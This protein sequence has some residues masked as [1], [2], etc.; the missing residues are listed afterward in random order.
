MEAIRFETLGLS[1]NIMKSLERMHFTEPTEVQALTVTPFLEG[2]DL[3]VQSPT[4]TGKTAAFGM[5][6]LQMIDPEVRATQALILCPTRELAL[7]ITEVLRSLSRSGPDVR[8]VTVYGGEN[9]SRQLAALRNV[10]HI[11]VA[12]PGRLLDHMQRKTVRLNTLRMVVVDEVDR[13]LDMGFRNDLK[14]I[15]SATPTARQT[16]M[17]SATLPQEIVF[18]ANQYQKNAEFITIEQ[19]SPVVE[20]VRHYY[21]SVY[22]GGKND[23]LFQLLEKEPFTLVFV[24]NKHRADRLKV[25]LQRRGIR[26]AALHGDMR[27]N[28]R[29]R[30]MKQYRSGALDTLVATD[31]AA[32]GIDVKNIDAVINYDI[33]QDNDSYVHRIGR[34]GRAKHEGVAYTI[35]FHDEANRLVDL[36]RKLK[37]TMEPIEGTE[38]VSEKKAAPAVQGKVSGSSF[39]SI[40]NRRRGRGRI[41]PRR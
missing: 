23:I 6:V 32:R 17:F 33:P 7:Q 38:P 18:L 30:V 16:V 29:D 28:E 36:M 4:G 20:T 3:L 11:V 40:N 35:L 22:P 8:I 1:D 13:M 34:T 12:T 10:A 14:K 37:I 41:A 26:A 15:L 9:I 21:A 5:P 24:N 2:K 25:Q 27:Q 19:P 31:V 39:H